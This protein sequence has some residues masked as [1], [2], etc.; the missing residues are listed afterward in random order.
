MQNPLA[1]KSN[2]RS[3]IPRPGPE[4]PCLG[5]PNPMCLGLTNPLSR[6]DKSYIQ[7]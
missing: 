5:L 4:T 2:F 3:A 6:F 1:D 7:V